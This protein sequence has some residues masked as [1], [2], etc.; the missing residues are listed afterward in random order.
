MIAFACPW[1]ARPL[2][3]E[4]LREHVVQAEA[5]A[6]DRVAGEQR[7]ERELV[8]IGLGAGE[9]ADEPP[10]G[11][12]RGQRRDRVG[13]RPCTAPSTAWPSALSALAASSASRL[14]GGERGV[15]DDDRAA[16]ARRRPRG[17]PRRAGGPRVI[18]APDSVVGIAIA[19][20]PRPS[21]AATALATSITRPPPSATTRSS[22]P[23]SRAHASA[24]RP[25]PG[26]RRRGTWCAPAAASAPR[27]APPRRARWSAAGSPGRRARD[28]L[29]GRG[30]RP[31]RIS[32]LAVAP[33][34][35]VRH[36]RFMI[37]ACAPV[38]Q[39]RCVARVGFRASHG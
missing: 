20:A 27:A 30:P 12:V 2:R 16:H 34:E 36:G 22:P 21:A 17:R 33:G 10:R 35:G 25:A 6:V 28:G 32:A 5:G 14:R 39:R 29:G 23:W 31:K 3:D 15:V 26:P 18:S 7:A 9:R 1:P 19:R 38:A 37:A 13:A 8:A 4:R 11:V 24:P